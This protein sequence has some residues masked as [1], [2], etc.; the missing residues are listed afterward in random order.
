MWLVNHSRVHVCATLRPFLST[1][2]IQK[3]QVS[4]AGK[5]FQKLPHYSQRKVLPANKEKKWLNNSSGIKN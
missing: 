2:E 5:Y 3:V 1:K 4:K